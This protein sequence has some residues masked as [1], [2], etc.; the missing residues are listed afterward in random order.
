MVV[1]IL[2][3]CLLYLVQ[4]MLHFRFSKG[5]TQRVSAVKAFQ[6]LGES[7]PVFFILAVLSLVLDVS[8]NNFISAAWLLTRIIFVLVYVSGFGRKPKLE[9]GSDYEPQPLRSLAWLISILLL[10]VMAFNIVFS[11]YF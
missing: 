9:D 11:V 5:S 6:N 4:L 7:V 10:V 3:V 2:L 8:N 1:I